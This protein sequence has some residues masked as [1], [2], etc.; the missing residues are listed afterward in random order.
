MNLKKKM[1]YKRLQNK[2]III[3]KII[4]TKFNIKIFWNQMLKD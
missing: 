4:M 2:I 1:Q 3:K